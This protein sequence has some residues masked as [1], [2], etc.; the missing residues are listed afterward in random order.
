LGLDAGYEYLI[1]FDGRHFLSS[2]FLINA[3]TRRFQR[4]KAAT[5]TGTRQTAETRRTLRRQTFSAENFAN[6]A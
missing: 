6:N 2:G 3:K 4:G 5:K 1:N